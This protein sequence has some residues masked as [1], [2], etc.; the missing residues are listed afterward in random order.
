MWHTRCW[1]LAD[2]KLVGLIRRVALLRT[3]LSVVAGARWSKPVCP[4][5]MTTDWHR[6]RIKNL[7]FMAHHHEL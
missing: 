5:L 1:A 4:A 7:L 2:E 6:K 3:I